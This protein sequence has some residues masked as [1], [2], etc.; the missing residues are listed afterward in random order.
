MLTLSPYWA[1]LNMHSEKG[2]NGFGHS[3]N[4]GAIAMHQQVHGFFNA[5]SFMVGVLGGCIACRF[6]DP[7]DQ[8]GTS[9]ALGLV[10]SG[11]GLTTTIKEAIMPNN[12][13]TNPSNQN[14]QSFFSSQ[15][16]KSRFISNSESIEQLKN[17]LIDIS[18]K[19]GAVAEKNSQFTHGLARRFLKLDKSLSQLT[20]AEFIEQ[21]NHATKS[22]NAVFGGAK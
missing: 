6:L 11:G 3:K 15:E 8:P 21:I 2:V 18:I 19:I 14:K 5:Y 22:Y 13:T 16:S 1:I 17:Q 20:I 12:H 10:T 9:T 4:Q 7:V